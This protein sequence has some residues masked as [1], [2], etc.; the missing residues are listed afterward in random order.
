LHL[1]GQLLTLIHDAW[2]QEHKKLMDSQIQKGQADHYSI[3][4]HAWD[5]LQSVVSCINPSVMVSI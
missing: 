1:V 4:S 3:L 2:T 5:N